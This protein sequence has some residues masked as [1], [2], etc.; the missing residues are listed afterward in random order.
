[1][2]VRPITLVVNFDRNFINL[3]QTFYEIKL[4]GLFFN[5]WAGYQ[6]NPIGLILTWIVQFFI[7]MWR[8]N[9]H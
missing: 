1:L 3:S 9:L 6:P 7:Q 5:W 2:K 4:D 8:M